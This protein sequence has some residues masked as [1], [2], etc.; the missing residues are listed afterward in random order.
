LPKRLKGKKKRSGRDF[1][2][3]W[4][5]DVGGFL[6]K[7]SGEAKVWTGKNHSK[8]KD[9]REGTALTKDRKE[10]RGGAEQ[11]KTRPPQK[12]GWGT[13]QREDYGGGRP[14]CKK[15]GGG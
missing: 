11:E 1:K 9:R 8:K 4:G 15:R 5:K 7:E 6:I 3:V 13:N 2:S 12:P 10:A 14:C